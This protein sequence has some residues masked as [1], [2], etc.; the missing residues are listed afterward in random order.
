GNEP[1]ARSQRTRQ[2]SAADAEILCY[3]LEKHAEGEDQD[4]AGADQEPA[5]AGEH[6]PPAAGENPGHDAI[7]AQT[8]GRSV[9]FATLAVRHGAHKRAQ[10]AGCYNRTKMR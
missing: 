5:G 8:L 2:I 7:T 4:R 3:G 10:A 1:G 6:D 9:L